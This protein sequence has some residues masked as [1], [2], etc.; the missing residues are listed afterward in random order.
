MKKILI[1]F[2]LCISFFSN[3]HAETQWY[4]ATSYAYKTMNNYGYWTN[5]TNWI[6][7]NISIKFDMSDDVIVIYS[8]R[9]Q[10]YAIYNYRGQAYD[11]NGGIQAYFD[12]IDQD[13]DKG[14]IRLRI[15]QNGNSQ[16]YCEFANVMWVYNVY[17]NS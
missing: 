11:S 17:R 15:E 10:I 14:T 8:N 6:N 13:Y 5:W 9:T 4:K 12:V 16:I 7:C 3:A 1:L 2:L